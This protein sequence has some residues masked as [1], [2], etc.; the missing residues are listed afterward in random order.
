M[1]RGGIIISHDYINAVGVRKAFDEFFEDKLEPIIEMS[2]SQ[3]L[4]AKV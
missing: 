3:C 4:I 1:N 2:G